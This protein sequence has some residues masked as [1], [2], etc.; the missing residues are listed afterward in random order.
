MSAFKFFSLLEETRVTVGNLRVGGSVCKGQLTRHIK[1]MYRSD[2]C[3]NWKLTSCSA[4]GTDW[5]LPWWASTHLAENFVRPPRDVI[6]KAI[7]NP[8]HCKQIV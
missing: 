8:D 1:G 4:L 3:G 2:T 6:W 7:C 5:K